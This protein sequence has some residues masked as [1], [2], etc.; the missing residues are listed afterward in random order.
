MLPE[1]AYELIDAFE[2]NAP[3]YA[4]RTYALITDRGEINGFADKKEAVLQAVYKI[5]NTERYRYPVYSGD[6]G[7]EL[8]DLYGLDADYVG[9]EAQRRITEALTADG[10]ITGVSD[11]DFA[12]RG[13][14]I[15]FSFTVNT[16]YGDLTAQKEIIF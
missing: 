9:V 6:Y 16:V 1:N 8:S 15:R 2:K 7:V 3:D 11:F 5:L 4:D 13:D 10:R 12:A 14:K